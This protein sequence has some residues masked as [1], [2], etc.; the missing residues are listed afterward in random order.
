MKQL[1]PHTI[2]ERLNGAMRTGG[3]F[4]NLKRGDEPNTM[5][6][7]WGTMGIAWGD[8]VFMTMVRHSRHSHGMMEDARRFTVSIPRPGE[9][10]EAL[11][12]CGVKSGRDTDKFAAAGLTAVPAQ[13][14]EGIVIGE[15]DLHL[16]CEVVCASEMQPDGLDESIRGAYKDGDYHTLYFGRIV[17]CYST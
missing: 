3:V 7:S 14:V 15:C 2:A 1:E 13:A 12:L 4:L 17:R 9:L 11:A 5:T 6:I 8:D 16:E 10:K